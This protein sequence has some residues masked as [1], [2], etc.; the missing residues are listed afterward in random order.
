M[1]Q[2]RGL[3]V[4]GW[5]GAMLG[6]CGGPS[7]DTTPPTISPDTTPPTI[8]EVRVSPGSLRFS[9]GQVTISARVSDPSGVGEVWAEVEKPNGEK[10]KVG[11]RL[12][13][14]DVYEGTFGADPNLRNDGQGERYRVWVR[15]KDGKGNETPLPGLPSGGVDFSVEA[16]LKPPEQPSL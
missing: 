12:G 3:L 14:N 4:V 13:S 11:M 6:G 9:G 16:P 1:R 2:G 5:I 15:A 10:R 8:S 7:P